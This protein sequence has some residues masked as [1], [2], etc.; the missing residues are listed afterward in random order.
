M[1][2]YNA[3]LPT[4]EAEKAEICEMHKCGAVI[5]NHW[6]ASIGTSCHAKPSLSV[7]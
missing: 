2:H 5:A 4:V 6:Y 7:F 1:H 3:V